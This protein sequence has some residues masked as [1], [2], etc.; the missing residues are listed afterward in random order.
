MSTKKQLEQK[1]KDLE[2]TLEE[3]RKL[4]KGCNISD[5]SVD[6]NRNETSIAIANA[7]EEGMRALQRIGDSNSY[8]IYIEGVK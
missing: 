3:H 6:M 4:G 5:V 8:G 1:I 2:V 7:V